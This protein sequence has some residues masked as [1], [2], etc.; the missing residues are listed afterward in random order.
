MLKA[1]TDQAAVAINK[2][3]LQEVA[4]TDF[5]TG[6]FIRR[7]FMSRLQDELIRSERYNKTFS[8]AM[9]D[10]D[11]FKNVN[12][13][14]G[15]S[16]GDQVLK[17]AGRFFQKNLRQTDVIARYGGEEFVIFF[18]ETNKDVAYILAER[19]RKGFSQIRLD[20]LPRLTISLGISSYPGDGK[21]IETLIKNAD[22]AMYTAKQ[23]GR[24]KVVNFS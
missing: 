11:K 16:A 15:H 12:D 8:I 19:L 1:V 18:P 17:E 22:M 13:T 2:A 24:N 7:Y 23:N 10:I 20:K 14:Y 5:L 6:L 21:D 9:V 3:Q 4:I